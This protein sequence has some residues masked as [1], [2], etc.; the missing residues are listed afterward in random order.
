[1]S[2]KTQSSNSTRIVWNYINMKSFL[3]YSYVSFI[4]YATRDYGVQKALSVP[5]SESI[6]LFPAGEKK[7]SRW[8]A[9]ESSMRSQGYSLDQVWMNNDLTQNFALEEDSFLLFRREETE[10]VFPFQSLSVPRYLMMTTQQ[11]RQL[12]SQQRRAFFTQISSRGTRATSIQSFLAQ[13]E[14]K[15]GNLSQ[16]LDS[17]NTPAAETIVSS[18]G[19]LHVEHL[20]RLFTHENWKISTSWG[21]ES[22]DVITLGKHTPYNVAVAAASTRRSGSTYL[23]RM[24]LMIIRRVRMVQMITL[25]VCRKNFVYVGYVNNNKPSMMMVTIMRTTIDYGHLTNYV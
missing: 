3:E 12:L 20:E 5:I 18:D 16:L 19:E 1:M 2:C 6:V 8:A 15:Y 21:L 4:L 25:R 9:N 14:I 13:I 11:C 22:S 24:K 10:V 23:M 17:P 7:T